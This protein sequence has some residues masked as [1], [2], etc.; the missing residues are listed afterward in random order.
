M[1]R[2]P[3]A[4]GTAANRILLAVVIL[5]LPW[6]IDAQQQQQNAGRDVGD[7]YKSPREAIKADPIATLEATTLGNKAQ[8]LE[9]PVNAG[10]AKGTAGANKKNLDNNGNDA[11]AIAAFAP[12]GSAVRAPSTGR[13]SIENNAG[14]SPQ[15][16]RSLEDWDVEDFVLLATVDGKL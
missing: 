8:R 11:S 2:R 16:A 12:A 13:S 7:Q 14:L 15:S 4:E 5:L 1:P 6:L 10:R 9:S 3:P